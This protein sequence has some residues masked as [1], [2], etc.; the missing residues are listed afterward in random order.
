MTSFMIGYY[1]GRT[2]SSKE[3]GTEH[4]QKWKEWI[5]SLG[6]SVINAGTPLLNSSLITKDGVE[7]DSSTSSMKG[8]AI[9]KAESLSKAIEMAKRDP[10]LM[11]D[12]TIRI[13]EMVEMKN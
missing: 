11:I 8:F 1:G 7:K 5:S 13:S 4:M 9:I 12:G 3:D 6:S 10:F 2:P